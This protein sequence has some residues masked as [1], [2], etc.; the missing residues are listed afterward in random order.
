MSTRSVTPVVEDIRL[1]V[2]PSRSLLALYIP[3]PTIFRGFWQY[4]RVAV[5][6]RTFS[7]FFDSCYHTPKPRLKSMG[8]TGIVSQR[9]REIIS[10]EQPCK[11]Y[12]LLAKDTLFHEQNARTRLIVASSKYTEVI[13]W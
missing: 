8:N 11:V 1:E 10:L 2:G 12:H 6:S 13:L 5:L 9:I 3:L 4:D 7:A